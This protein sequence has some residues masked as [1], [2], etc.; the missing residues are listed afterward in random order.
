MEN[1]S[2][3]NSFNYLG[4]RLDSQSHH[5]ATNPTVFVNKYK[6]ELISAIMDILLY[7]NSSKYACRPEHLT[8]KGRML[9]DKYQ[10]YVEDTDEPLTERLYS[11]LR[12]LVFRSDFFISEYTHID[13]VYFILLYMAE[14]SLFFT[15]SDLNK[16][17]TSYVCDYIMKERCLLE[18]KE[19]YEKYKEFTSKVYKKYQEDQKKQNVSYHDFIVEGRFILNKF[20]SEAGSIEHLKYEFLLYSIYDLIANIIMHNVPLQDYH[21]L[22]MIYKIIVLGGTWDKDLFKDFKD[23]SAMDM[24]L[25]STYER[26][27]DNSEFLLKDIC[28]FIRCNTDIEKLNRAEQSKLRYLIKL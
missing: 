11:F 27:S 26:F 16:K 6:I 28:H 14:V 25:N 24:Y 21:Q 22:H 13:V 2:F 10:K 19:E 1:I 17:L 3:V 12:N 7:D 23:V 4:F 15:D 9:Y 8:E 5:C 18:L 20:P